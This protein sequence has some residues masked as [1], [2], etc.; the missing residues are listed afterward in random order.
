MDHVNGVRYGKFKSLG[1]SG[2]HGNQLQLR[3]NPHWLLEVCFLKRSPSV[4]FEFAGLRHLDSMFDKDSRIPCIAYLLK[5]RG[6]FKPST[7]L[8]A[9][10]SPSRA[11]GS[12]SLEATGNAMVQRIPFQS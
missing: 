2:I 12:S 6:M 4:R 9:E 1:G 5:C 3:D 11:P 7:M 8:V 10:L